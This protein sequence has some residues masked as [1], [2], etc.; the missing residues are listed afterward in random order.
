MLRTTLQGSQYVGVYAHAADHGCLVGGPVDDA[1]VE[2]IGSEVGTAVHPCTVGGAATVGALVASNASGIVVSGRLTTGER[3]TVAAATEGP[4]GELPGRINA[5]G[6]CLLV[7]DSGAI[8]HPDLR[9]SA[10]AVVE[11]TLDVA[12]ERMSI[13]GVKTVGT[14]AVATERGVLCHPKVTDEELDRIEAALEVRAD[15]GTVNYGSPLVGSGLVANETG[16][17]VGQDT[18]GP[19]LGRIEEALGFLA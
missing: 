16:F 8:A 13:G 7:N 1:T 14:A 3:E 4:L 12:V 10:V 17:V 11:E 5:A 15:V 6:N 2:A 9:D 18:T 19:E